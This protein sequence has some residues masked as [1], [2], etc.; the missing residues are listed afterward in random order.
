MFCFYY[1]PL[2]AY[3]MKLF[4]S[5]IVP[6]AVLALTENQCN[7]HI[8]DLGYAKHA[9]SWTNTTTHGTTLL[10]YNNIRYAQPPL[11][12]LRFRRPAIPP[13]TNIGIS[14]GNL[15]TSRDEFL[16]PGFSPPQGFPSSWQTDCLSSA[17]AVVPFPLLNGS[18]WG[19]ED[20]L[21]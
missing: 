5:V 4:T 20:C 1:V 8:I 9:V 7:D 16:P 13:P 3:I 21:L 10:N 6:V 14:F 17:P 12:D 19:S 18:T 11:G 2:V 15:T